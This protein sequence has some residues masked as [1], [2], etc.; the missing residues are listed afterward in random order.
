MKKNIYYLCVGLI[1][2]SWVVY[3]THFYGLLEPY[4]RMGM[5]SS[6]PVLYVAV[7]SWGLICLV[8]AS[9]FMEK[10]VSNLILGDGKED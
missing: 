9:F 4:V 7:E 6:N 3:S 8:V 10:L 5:P 1:I 2:V